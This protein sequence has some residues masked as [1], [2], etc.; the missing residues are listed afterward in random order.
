MTIEKLDLVVVIPA[1]N[2]GEIIEEVL[3]TGLKSLLNLR[4][5]MIVINDGSTDETVKILDKWRINHPEH[6]LLSNES[7]HGPSLVNGYLRLRIGNELGLS[8]G[9]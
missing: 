7:G 1:F 8:S 4:F 3:S 9:F 5:Q 6:R 2:E